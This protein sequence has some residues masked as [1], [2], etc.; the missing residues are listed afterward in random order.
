MGK[1]IVTKPLMAFLGEIKRGNELDVYAPNSY[2]PGDWALSFRQDSQVGMLF[3]F[4]CVT[5]WAFFMGA[6]MRRSDLEFERAFKSYLELS[7]QELG[8]TAQQCRKV[9]ND[10]GTMKLVRT[11]DSVLMGELTAAAFMMEEV[12]MDGE[13]RGIKLERDEVTE[14]MNYR[15]VKSL[16]E[17]MPSEAMRRWLKKRYG[18][19]IKSRTLMEDANPPLTNLSDGP[20]DLGVLGRLFEQYRDPKEGL[21]S[22]MEIEGLLCATL[23]SPGA[24]S[25]FANVHAILGSNE[26]NWRNEDDAR[27]FIG[28]LMGWSN[29]LARTMG[30]PGGSFSPLFAGY[31]GV[32]YSAAVKEWCTGFVHG[33]IMKFGVLPTDELADAVRLIL[34][35]SGLLSEDDT[36]SVEFIGKVYDVAGSSVAPLVQA[37]FKHSQKRPDWTKRL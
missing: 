3:G 10:I 11:R 35:L 4:H 29:Q 15:T 32:A 20:V 25:P 23:A 1:L 7:L 6:A 2:G 33:W 9:M 28:N 34:C 12:L 22:I 37:L 26:T 30:G 5:K 18:F 13:E 17:T 19:A 21:K 8:L 24:L 14:M 31:S 36:E 16:G 27:G